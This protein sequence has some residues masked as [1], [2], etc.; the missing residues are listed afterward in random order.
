MRAAPQHAEGRMWPAG[1]MLPMPGLKEQ[2]Y[3]Y[4][5]SE[6]ICDPYRFNYLKHFKNHLRIPNCMINF[7]LMISKNISVVLKSTVHS[8][9]LH[10]HPKRIKSGNCTFLENS[11]Y[12]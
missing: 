3:N 11:D 5:I 8:A 6:H 4:R 2:V 7:S 1:R 9:S 12:V 10:L